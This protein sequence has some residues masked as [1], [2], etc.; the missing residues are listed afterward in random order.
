MKRALTWALTAVLG[1][2]VSWA[3]LPPLVAAQEAD[4]PALRAHRS[5]RSSGHHRARKKAAAA[6]AEGTVQEPVERTSKR[7]RRAHRE[8]VSTAHVRA[9]PRTETQTS[10]AAAHT[11]AEVGPSAAETAAQAAA[12]GVNAQIVKEGDTSVKVMEFTGLGIEG[13]LKS[14]QLVYFVQR[15]R[16]EFERPVLPH[17]SFMPELEH[18]TGREPV[19]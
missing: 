9:E 1:S 6:A 3:V 15:V 13:R 4:K 12:S 5:S 7:K 19:R 18:S 17:R 8:K 16:A 2:A 10:T 11:K 14:P